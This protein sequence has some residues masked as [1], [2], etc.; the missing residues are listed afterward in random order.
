MKAVHVLT[1]TIFMFLGAT[2]TSSTLLAKTTVK[3]TI[4][5]HQ[6][7]WGKASIIP[8]DNRY[9][10]HG[11]STLNL[12]EEGMKWDEALEAMANLTDIHLPMDTKPSKIAYRGHVN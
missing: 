1:L 2:F 9:L 8:T 7:E 11:I 6:A 12:V 5:F 3:D 4:F 10:S